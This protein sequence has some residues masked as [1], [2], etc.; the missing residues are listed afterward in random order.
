MIQKLNRTAAR[1]EI[2]KASQSVWYI[3]SKRRVK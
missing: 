2:V 3:S 1:T